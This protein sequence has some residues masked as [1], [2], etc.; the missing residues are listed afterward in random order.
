MTGHGCESAPC[1]TAN[2]NTADA[3]T[4]AMTNVRGWLVGYALS[5]LYMA[6]IPTAAPIPEISFSVWDVV[7]D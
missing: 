7:S 2:T 4:D 3:A 6:R 5:T 1:G